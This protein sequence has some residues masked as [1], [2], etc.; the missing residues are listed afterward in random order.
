MLIDWQV[1]VF[2]KVASCEHARRPTVD[3][4]S[5]G[6]VAAVDEYYDRVHIQWVHREAKDMCTNDGK[7]PTAPAPL[8]L[9]VMSGK[10]F[11]NHSLYCGFR[12]LKD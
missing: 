8:A 2:E 7:I 4:V 11:E 3:Q 6:E 1:A 5:G 10:T 12:Y 9:C